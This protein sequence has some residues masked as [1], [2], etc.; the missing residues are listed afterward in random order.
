M[1]SGKIKKSTKS[2]FFLFNSL[3]K[4]IL[5]KILSLKTDLIHILNVTYVYFHYIG[6][7]YLLV[8]GKI[9]LWLLPA[10]PY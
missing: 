5:S 1:F 9:L 4:I 8:V 3:S 10:K 6:N 7:L 2:C